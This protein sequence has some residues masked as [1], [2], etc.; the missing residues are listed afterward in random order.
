MAGMNA[1]GI[2][3]SQQPSSHEHCLLFGSCC[4]FPFSRTSYGC[5]YYI[6]HSF[7]NL[8]LALL[9]TCVV[10]PGQELNFSCI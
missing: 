3:N 10:D 4:F 2:N 8:G 7:F 9:P 5:L 6:N 1:D